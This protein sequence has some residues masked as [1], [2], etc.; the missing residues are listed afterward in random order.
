MLYFVKI[1][2]IILS[3]FIPLNVESKELTNF[4]KINM[5][6]TSILLDEKK[7]E[8]L[9]KNKVEITVGDIFIEGHDALL[10]FTEE[11]LTINGNPA[12]IFSKSRGVNGSA[13]QII[14][15]PNNSIEMLGNAQ[16]INKERSISSE[17]IVYQINFND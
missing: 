14:V 6:A 11:V 10:D 1:S 9:F 12:S 15:H 8:L 7:N 5:H 17:E 16:L 4:K 2:F 13:D 3:L